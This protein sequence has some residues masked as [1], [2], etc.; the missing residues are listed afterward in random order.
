M[1][2]TRKADIKEVALGTC[3]EQ[4]TTDAY[5]DVVG[6]LVDTKWLTS[7][8]YTIENTDGANDLDWQVLASNDGGEF[9]VVKAEDTVGEGAVDIYAVAQAPYRY[10][11]VQVKATSG[12]NQADALVSYIAK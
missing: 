5:A 4:V 7:L 1:I 11:K 2:D 9:V 6:S 8:S 12:G 3:D 10:Y